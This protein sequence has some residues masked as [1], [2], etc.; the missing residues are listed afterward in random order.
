M[1]ELTV[2]DTNDRVVQR[3]A[4]F[5]I[6]EYGITTKNEHD[7]EIGFFQFGHF[8]YVVADG[9]QANQQSGSRT[10]GQQSSPQR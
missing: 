10:T 1:T 4:E 3:C 7:E 8:A 6:G 2:V 5:E 9:Q